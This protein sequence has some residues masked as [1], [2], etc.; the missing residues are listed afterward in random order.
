MNDKESQKYLESFLIVD[1]ND[2]NIKNKN[3]S[4]KININVFNSDSTSVES[5]YLPFSKKIKK[6][7]YK[8]NSKIISDYKRSESLSRSSS[9]YIDKKKDEFFNMEFEIL[10][11]N[12]IET[13]KPFKSKCIFYDKK[14][15]S[16]D[17]DLIIDKNYICSFIP[18]KNKKNNLNKL[19]YNSDYY[20][21]SLF[22]IKNINQNTN[23]LG[24]ITYYVEIILKDCRSFL[25]KLPM[26]TYDFFIN[27]ITK[28]F[29]PEKNSIF[30]EK[31]FNF[32]I[33][34]KKNNQKNYWNLYDIQKEFIRQGVD[35]NLV[36][37]NNP[38]NKK[39]KYY[40]IDNTSFTICE[41]YPEKII[42]PNLGTK[43][44]LDDIKI[45]SN[46]RTKKRLPV[47]TYRHDNGICLWRCSQ[48]KSGFNG[49]NEKDI[50]LLTKI[51]DNNK[52]IIYDCRPK[53][54][55]WVNKLKGAG[56]ENKD[57]YHKINME[58]KFCDIPNIHA[59]RS[60]F[61]AVFN[62]VSYITWDS[63]QSQNFNTYS[64]LS[65]TFW[66]DMIILILKSSFNI[67]KSI[68]K[69]KNTV[70][71]HCSDGWDRTSQLAC[72]SKILLDKYYRTLEGF[73]ILIEKDWMSFGHQFRYRNGFY[74]DKDTPAN[75]CKENQF[76]PIFIQW[77]DCVYQLM[78]QNLDKFEFN[79]NLLIFIAEQIY[80]GNYG[81]FLF[82]NEKERKELKM[83]IK[84]EN[85]WEYVLE[86][87]K[88]FLNP[89]FNRKK[90]DNL[91]LE[92]NYKKIKL[93]EDY[94]FRFEKGEKKGNYI[95][96]INDKFKKYKT[97]IKKKNK[98]LEEMYKIIE[99][100]NKNLITPE[101]KKEL[102]IKEEEIK[103][104]VNNSDQISFVVLN[105][106]D[107]ED[108][109]K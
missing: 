1:E 16:F 97:E 64:N 19:Y 23:L 66:Y 34:N 96:L 79:E 7:P 58:I 106:S 41:S 68:E 99:K 59:V 87:K 89:I 55:A 3:I 84:T 50:L 103:E 81:N 101:M 21:F 77:L 69:D 48:T 102:G 28:Y 6:I 56:Y 42:V 86:N 95:N 67:Y 94:F 63:T 57:H 9:I 25:F 36:D 22:Y 27:T 104:P 74:S 49:K 44:I 60:S 20:S 12:K 2:I 26:T 54:N 47:L 90:E 37:N 15:N 13:I 61:E 107:F 72:T 52:L 45:C 65:N 78:E 80:E 18:D 92:I 73:I 31:A 32:R 62:S 33:K 39:N 88:R 100:N 108:I 85:I 91:V 105:K 38:S 30:F 83:K 76:S 53:L 8:E 29:K 51:A 14:N 24:Q 109:K 5:I 70:L 98:I 17:G 82:N 10:D 35:F 4:N 46:F 71:I 40:L 43:N 93:W 11:E 75:I